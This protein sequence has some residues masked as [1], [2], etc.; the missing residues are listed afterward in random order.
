LETSP[1]I[2]GATALPMFYSPCK[3][4]RQMQGRRGRL[5]SM[6]WGTFQDAHYRPHL[7]IARLEAGTSETKVALLKRLASALGVSG[8]YAIKRDGTNVRVA[9][10]SDVD[11]TR[12]ANV[13]AATVTTR[14]PEWASR[15]VARIDDATQRRITA[16]LRKN[17]LKNA[18]KR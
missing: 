8:S 15:A 9:F 12:F 18:K 2:A 10:E 7:V 6:N 17:H 3:I 4:V 11:A 14:E 16:A 1:A 5:L 13:L